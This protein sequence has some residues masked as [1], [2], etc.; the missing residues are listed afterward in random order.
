LS[1][2]VTGTVTVALSSADARPVPAVSRP[3]VIRA[4]CSPRFI[5]TFMRGVLL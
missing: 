5:H 3:P 1:V 2:T 4:V